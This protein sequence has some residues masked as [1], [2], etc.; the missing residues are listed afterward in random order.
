M[1][2]LLLIVPAL[3]A[4]VALAGTVGTPDFAAADEP[5]VVSDTLVVTGEGSV[6]AAPDEA[7]FSFGVETRGATAKAALSANGA[8]IRNV[9]AALRNAGA[10][11]LATQYISVWPLSENGSVSGYTASNSVSATIGIDRAGELIDAATAA[12][13]NN[14][15][16][17][18]MS[19][20]DADRVYRRALAAA[21]A[22]AR[23]RAGALAKAA[24]RSLGGIA[25]ISE[26]AEQA[27]PYYE[28]AALAAD[29]ATPV[30]PG[31]QKT[32]ATVSVTFELR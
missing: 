20:S 1:T 2:R 3:V 13:A 19:Q 10:R 4:V 25:K 9:L 26:G 8:E 15:S 16:G 18:T 5:A 31:K 22:D 23:A 32:S 24:G 30:V 21:I 11:D 27:V 7:S 28:R 14:L 17:P 12:G 6:E 29:S